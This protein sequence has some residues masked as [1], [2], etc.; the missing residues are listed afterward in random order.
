MAQLADLTTG[1]LECVGV[2]TQPWKK[3][4]PARGN[5]LS[6]D[7]ALDNSVVHADISVKVFE[8]LDF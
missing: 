2:P 4:L 8:H 1:P 5:F 7:W 6:V 3:A